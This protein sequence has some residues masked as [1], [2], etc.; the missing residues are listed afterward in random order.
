MERGFISALLGFERG[1]ENLFE[2]EGFRRQIFRVLRAE[3]LF[4]GVR[5]TVGDDF[6]FAANGANA[7]GTYE[8]QLRRR[9]GEA[10]AEF[11]VTVARAVSFEGQYRAACIHD[12]K[13]VDQAFKFTDQVRRDKYCAA[14]RMAF[15]VCAN[16]CFNEFAA[17]DWIEAGSRFIENEQ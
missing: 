9:T 11:F 7:D 6:E 14:T 2:R 10:C 17:D 1:D 16:D 15:L 5:R 3:M 13:F 8:I 12:G 4:D